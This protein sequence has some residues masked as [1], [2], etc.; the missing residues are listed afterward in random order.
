MLGKDASAGGQFGR[1]AKST[2]ALNGSYTK[3]FT[4]SGKAR[5][6][7]HESDSAKARAGSVLNQC[8]I[9]SRRATA[10]CWPR[11]KSSTPIDREPFHS[12][13]HARKPVS[14]LMTGCSAP[15]GEGRGVL[16][17]NPTGIFSSCREITLRLPATLGC[18]PSRQDKFINS[19]TAT[20]V[21]PIT[22]F[23]S[24]MN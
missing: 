14:S 24:F 3:V 21:Q 7:L 20:T 6:S 22:I 1:T 8:S 17:G 12:L 19:D 9:C 10:N 13:S 2:I 15:T 23:L 4:S 11:V 5:H 16:V 18:H